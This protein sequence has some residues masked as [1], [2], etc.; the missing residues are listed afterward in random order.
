MEITEEQFES[1]CNFVFDV[2]ADFPDMA[3]LD[4]FDIQDIAVTR[5]VLIPTTVYKPCQ[6]EGCNC[7]E[8]YSDDD[9]K[10]GATCYKLV[11]WLRRVA[12]QRNGA[13]ETQH[14]CPS[15]DGEGTGFD[16]GESWTCSTCNG[17]G[18]V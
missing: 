14:T 5:K 4:G 3:T 2:L 17:S 16:E 15:C 18:Q 12:E 6:E 11:G 8:F 9:F 13:A 7:S 1:L 10:A